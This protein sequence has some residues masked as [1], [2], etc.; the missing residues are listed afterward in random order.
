MVAVEVDVEEEVEVVVKT[1]C[2]DKVDVNFDDV[3]A[4]AFGSDVDI[5]VDSAAVDYVGAVAVVDAVADIDVA[6]VDVADIVAVGCGTGRN[7]WRRRRGG[8]W[9][10]SP[11]QIMRTDKEA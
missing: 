5:A 7:C 9:D 10:S 1:T 4:A 8:C 2:L 11:T 3:A 6:V